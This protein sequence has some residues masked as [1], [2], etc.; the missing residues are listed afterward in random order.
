MAEI[1]LIHGDCMDL[2]RETP[3]NYFDLCVTDP[4]YGV[5]LLYNSYED[6]PENWESLMLKFIP[7]AK[8]VS[9]MLVFPSCSIKKMKWIYDN[10]PPDWIMA[11]TK[12]ITG[13]V[14]HI[15]FNDWEPLLV[16][17][18]LKEVYFHDHIKINNNEKMGSYKHPCPKP[19]KFFKWFYVRIYGKTESPKIF[20]PFLG[21]G[22]SAIACHDMGFDLTAT[23]IDEDY[24]KAAKKRFDNHK[25]QLSIF[26]P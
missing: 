12:G 15:G 20:D 2:M 7:E 21:S 10:F 22:T 24:F 1:K 19:V 25:A 14:S 4:P 6:S 17:G 26:A 8:R 16:Y 9:R 11:W 13:H 3:D 23:E 18:K 5:N